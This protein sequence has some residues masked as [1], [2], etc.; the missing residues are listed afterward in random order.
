[1]GCFVG[2]T[3]DLIVPKGIVVFVSGSGTGA[4]R[5]VTRFCN[6][7]LDMFLD[8]ERHVARLNMAEL[9]KGVQTEVT[10]VTVCVA[11]V[12]FRLRGS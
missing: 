11:R 8:R 12:G 1:M 10:C 3:E 2:A 9:A 4:E 6:I 7:Y 5:S